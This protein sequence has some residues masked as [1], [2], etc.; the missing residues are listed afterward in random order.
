MYFPGFSLVNC[1]VSF[2]MNFQ[3]HYFLEEWVPK[4]ECWS[5]TFFLQH[6]D[7]RLSSSDTQI[8]FTTVQQ[9]PKSSTAEMVYFWDRNHYKQSNGTAKRNLV[10]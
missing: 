7:S 2:P 4:F 10:L 8:W 1:F 3:R 6:F 9:I 5:L